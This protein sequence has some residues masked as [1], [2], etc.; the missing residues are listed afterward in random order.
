MNMPAFAYS[1]RNTDLLTKS[2]VPKLVALPIAVLIEREIDI[3]IKLVVLQIM[4]E[5]VNMF[6][7]FLYQLVQDLSTVIF[8]QVV[9][10]M[11][12]DQLFDVLGCVE[13]VA[14]TSTVSDCFADV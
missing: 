13:L 5:C 9:N 1:D 12:F 10:D 6:Y 7:L 14:E 2:K 3:I 4:R 11:S 8:S